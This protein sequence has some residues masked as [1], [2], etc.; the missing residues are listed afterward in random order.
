MLVSGS[1]AFWVMAVASWVYLGWF[2]YKKHHI[3]GL[4]VYFIMTAALAAA[5]YFL[6]PVFLIAA[7]ILLMA[8]KA[9]D[10][11]GWKGLVFIGLLVAIA[12]VTI[13]FAPPVV[14]PIILAAAIFG[15]SWWNSKNTVNYKFHKNHQRFFGFMQNFQLKHSLEIGWK[16]IVLALC[17]ISTAP[18]LYL[19]L[20]A[21]VIS[22]LKAA[23]GA[24]CCAIVANP[25][26]IPIIIGVVVALT[27]FISVKV[28][29]ERIEKTPSSDHAGE[30]SNVWVKRIMT[31][32]GLLCF[33]AVIMVSVIG[34]Y[35][36]FISLFKNIPVAILGAIMSFVYNAC[37]SYRLINDFSNYKPTLFGGGMPKSATPAPA[38]SAET[39][40]SHRASDET[41]VSSDTINIYSP[42]SPSANPAQNS[43]P[44]SP[45]C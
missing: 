16:H 6:G 26:I 4:F 43:T 15:A 37:S 14:F 10:K 40:N 42:Q 31:G 11:A 25:Y 5:I 7:P 30:A 21:L 9:Y 27:V 20:K 29:W 12:A 41:A 32:L 28:I 18:F 36:G 2:L 22:L 23:G 8:A 3:K 24:A 17:A 35:S 45:V 13:M 1:P 39:K 34:D 44:T 38:Q 33:G 19:M